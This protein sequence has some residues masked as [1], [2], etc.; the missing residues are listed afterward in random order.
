MT[1]GTSVASLLGLQN[2]MAELRDDLAGEYS[3][4]KQKQEALQSERARL[5]AEIKQLEAVQLEQKTTKAEILRLKEE[6]VLQQ[7]KGNGLKKTENTS[8][9]KFDEQRR[10]LKKDI[11]MLKNELS[12][13]TQMK[14][15][16][17]A[18][19]SDRTIQIRMANENLQRKV[20]R[21]NKKV[22][23]MQEDLSVLKFNITTRQNK[24]LAEVQEVQKR[25]HSLQDEVLKQAQRVGQVNHARELLATQSAETV[26]QRRSLKESVEACSQELKN[27]DEEIAAAQLAVSGVNEKIQA[28]QNQDAENQKLVARLSKCKAAAAR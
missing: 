25:I 12:A 11:A 22:L 8:R 6:L 27:L 19:V 1:V 5:I 14:D 17:L 24:K 9:L 20:S 28:C 18:K 21:L 3:L 15:E 10:V 16:Y 23:Q 2:T 4:W 13:T 26:E 7:A